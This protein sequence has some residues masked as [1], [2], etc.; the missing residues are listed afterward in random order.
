MAALCRLHFK[1]GIDMKIHLV[2]G[3]YEL[4][5][6][7]FAVP[8][9]T[10]P[11]GRPVGAVRGLMQ[12]LLA[13]LRQDDV[14]H[15]AC[16]FDHVIESF[17][18]R[19]FSGY[20]TGDGT[21]E[22]L[23]SQ[24]GLAERAASSLGIVVWPMVEYEADDAIAT[25]ALRWWGAPGVEQ[26]VIC[27]PDK[28]LTQLVR[29]N[30]VVCLDR[31]KNVTMDENGVV[32]KFGVSPCSIPDY[33]ALV[34]DSADGIQG[35]PRWGAK[36]TAQ[37]LQRYGHIE[38]IPDQPSEWDLKLR[39]INTL[40]ASLS[41]HRDKVMLYKDLATLRLDVPLTETLDQLEWRGVLGRDYLLL[42]K[43]LGFSA[44]SELPHRWADE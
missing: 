21:P 4:F 7:Y 28:D 31:R 2:D 42:C 27:S 15:V 40:A 36:T 17:R 32:E 9:I 20:K 23:M 10:A 39:G 29:E 22:D 11:D 30:R 35:V 24:F 13:L 41:E 33:L 12:T 25:A 1:A 16:A 34:G 14:T 5:R 38:R 18:N 6:A 19:L 8:P 26:V 37:V 43:E 44:L 3:T